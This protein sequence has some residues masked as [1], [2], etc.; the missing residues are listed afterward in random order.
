MDEVAQTGWPLVDTKNGRPM[1]KYV[2]SSSPKA[3]SP[4]RP[5][6]SVV[7]H[8]D[9]TAGLIEWPVDGDVALAAIEL[10]DFHRDPADRFIVATAATQRATL[11]T[12][13]VAI[14]DWSSRLSRL[15]A[16]R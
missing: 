1:V 12:A 2:P 13:D 10:V 15:N 4:F 9:L 16:R 6:S 14:L 5:H 7:L 3:M 11:V 8:G